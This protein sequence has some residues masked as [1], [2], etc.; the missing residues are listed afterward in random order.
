MRPLNGKRRVLIT[1]G[2]RRLGAQLSLCL[3]KAGYNLVIHYYQS[4]A[5]AEKIAQKCREFNV[6][7][8]ILYGCF[9]NLAE[10]SRFVQGYV[11]QFT[12]TFA[13]INN[14]GNYLTS[15]AVHTSIEQWSALFQNNLHAP[16]FLTQSLLPLIKKEQGCVINIGTAGLNTGRSYVYASGY[17][18]AKQALFQLTKSFAK[19]LAPYLVRV[20]MIS[21]GH[22]EN[23]VDLLD[24]H[25]LPMK[26]AAQPDD[27]GSLLLFLL[28]DQ[29]GYITGQNIEVS[30]GFGL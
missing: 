6:D 14:V 18:I 22:L 29:G 30:G 21:P 11:E 24:P 28:G 16:F 13:L 8:E 15:S 23:S 5:E 17:N 3:A 4:L 10:L 26:R 9:D 2:A 27:I 20:N 19:E 1:G 25:L 7:V 12:D